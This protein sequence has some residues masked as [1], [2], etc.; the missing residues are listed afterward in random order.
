MQIQGNHAHQFTLLTCI[1]LRKFHKIR[2]IPD[3]MDFFGRSNIDLT[4][5]KNLTQVSSRRKRCELSTFVRSHERWESEIFKFAC[6]LTIN[7]FRTTY[8]FKDI[9]RIFLTESAIEQ[10]LKRTKIVILQSNTFDHWSTCKPLSI[11]ATGFWFSPVNQSIEDMITSW[12]N[13]ELNPWLTQKL[14]R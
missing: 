10:V 5:K 13:I 2:Y 3:W 4:K 12:R 7:S 14:P 1:L 9:K 11:I 8:T 6:L